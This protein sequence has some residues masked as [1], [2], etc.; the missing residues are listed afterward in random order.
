MNIGVNFSDE[1]ARCVVIVGLPYPNMLTPEF[2]A[3][4][5]YLR[6]HFVSTEISSNLAMNICMT[7]VNQA[8]GRVVR[9]KLD[10][11]IVVLLDARYSDSRHSSLI[12]KWA[13]PSF[14]RCTTSQN[15][16]SALKDFRGVLDC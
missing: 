1:L 12:S 3:K 11:G 5:E 15:A 7:Q 10:Y 4:T 13:Q 14:F 16:I 2:R 8:I 9:H 6:S